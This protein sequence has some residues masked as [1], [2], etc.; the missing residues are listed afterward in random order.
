MKA[1]SWWRDVK[2]VVFSFISAVLIRPRGEFYTEWYQP[3][4]DDESVEDIKADT[5]V[6]TQAV[7]DHFQQHFNGKQSAEE[8]VAVFQDLSQR[9]RLQSTRI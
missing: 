9:R 3:E 4:D 6:S 8:H 5:D 1:M 7:G 2:F